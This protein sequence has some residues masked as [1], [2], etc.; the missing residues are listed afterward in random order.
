M[1]SATGLGRETDTAHGPC[2]LGFPGG[3]VVNHLP[4]MQETSVWSLGR[5]VPLEE[6]TATHSAILVLEIPRTEEPGRLQ[7]LG[8]Q[9]VGHD[10][11]D[12]AQHKPCHLRAGLP[13]CHGAASA[14]ASSRKS[15]S[16]PW[17][18]CRVCKLPCCCLP[19][20]YKN[21]LS[22][23]CKVKMSNF[24]SY[25]IGFWCCMPVS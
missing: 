3:L 4:A 5:E 2:P 13:G 14:P 23:F 24:N 8:L 12:W 17:A 16:N 19:K 21:T 18:K 10:W 7:S 15:I 22:Y 20:A 11:S 1:Q 6:G 25:W 9:G